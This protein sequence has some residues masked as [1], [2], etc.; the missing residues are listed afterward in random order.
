MSKTQDLQNIWTCPILNSL[1][2]VSLCI[3]LLLTYLS[4]SVPD[5]KVN[6]QKLTIPGCLAVLWVMAALLESPTFTNCYSCLVELRLSQFWKSPNH[7]TKNNTCS[8]HQS[9]G[10]RAW[11]LIGMHFCGVLRILTLL[12]IMGD[13]RLLSTCCGANSLAKLEQCKFSVRSEIRW[14][15]NHSF[16]FIFF[17]SNFKRALCSEMMM[18]LP[19]VLYRYC[20]LMLPTSYFFQTFPAN[21]HYLRK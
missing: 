1:K 20:R 18:Q 19:R 13:K 5:I 17:L 6:L 8:L 10:N 14:G 4:S 21:L 3:A 16:C 15:G 12:G 2:G 7:L 9:V 11:R